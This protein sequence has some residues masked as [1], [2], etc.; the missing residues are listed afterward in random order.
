MIVVVLSL[1]SMEA[2]GCNHSLQVYRQATEHPCQGNITRMPMSSK[3]LNG[4]VSKHDR[5]ELQGGVR[6]ALPITSK[7]AL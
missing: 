1:C 2:R 3:T 6:P 4:L 5:K 7:H